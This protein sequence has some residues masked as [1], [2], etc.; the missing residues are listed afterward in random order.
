V[1]VELIKTSVSELM[2]SNQI[3]PFLL[4]LA[5]KQAKEFQEFK[6]KEEQVFIDV[7]QGKEVIS[8]HIKFLQLDMK[9]LADLN[10]ARERIQFLTEIQL[11]V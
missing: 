2:S 1:L 9:N 8:K 7:Y 3:L 4:R 6:I 5:E 10:L 11:Q